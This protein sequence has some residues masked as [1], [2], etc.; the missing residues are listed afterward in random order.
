M[1]EK[2]EGWFVAHG[3]R[4]LRLGL[5]LFAVSFALGAVGVLFGGCGSAQSTLS[6]QAA[7]H[8][9][10]Q[11]ERFRFYGEED[12]RCGGLHGDD[13]EAYRGCMAPATGVARAADVLR[14]T[15]EAAQAVLDASGEAELFDMVPSIVTA[16][17]HLIAALEAATVPIPDW[18]SDLVRLGGE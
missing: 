8:R 12:E 10:H 7:V 9:A 2:I 16:A 5:V 11:A 4:G 13:R 3:E 15:L 6:A 18:L 17:R 1:R 14:E